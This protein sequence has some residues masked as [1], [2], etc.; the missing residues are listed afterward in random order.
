MLDELLRLVGDDDEAGHVGAAADSPLSQQSGAVE[1]AGDPGRAGR[2]GEDTRRVAVHRGLRH[3]SAAA[4]IGCSQE[5]L[6]FLGDAI[7]YAATSRLLHAQLSHADEGALAV[8]DQA[9]HQGAHSPT[10]VATCSSNE[11]LSSARCS[12][13]RRG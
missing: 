10:W 3:S 1:P 9:R 5:R 2:R 13:L 11:W 6:E 12:R 7:L 4:Q 8:A